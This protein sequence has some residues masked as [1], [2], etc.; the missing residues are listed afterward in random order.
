MSI[1]MI[2]PFNV[3]IFDNWIDCGNKIVNNT[4][5]RVKQP[6]QRNEVITRTKQTALSIQ[7][8]FFLKERKS[9]LV[10]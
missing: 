3:S 6:H 5:I 2:I 1:K 7:Q 8:S 9:L 4:S 10:F